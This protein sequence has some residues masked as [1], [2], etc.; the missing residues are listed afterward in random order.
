MKSSDVEP[1][2]YQ[3]GRIL[4]ILARRWTTIHDAQKCPKGAKRSFLYSISP[5]LL[6]H[7]ERC[8]LRDQCSPL[9]EEGQR[10]YEPVRG[11]GSLPSL[12]VPD[13]SAIQLKSQAKP[14]RNPNQPT[15]PTSPPSPLSKRKEREKEKEKPTSRHLNL[16]PNKTLAD[17]NRGETACERADESKRTQT[18]CRLGIKCL[19]EWR[20]S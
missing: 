12:F 20:T 9:S 17:G 15:L 3:G 16:F 8:T 4:E 6:F 11:R 18:R 1:S 5:S 7:S 10:R 13:G 19:R 2:F 14:K